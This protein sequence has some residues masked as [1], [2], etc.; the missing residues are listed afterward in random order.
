MQT[1]C[2]EEGIYLRTWKRPFNLCGKRDVK[3][4][5]SLFHASPAVVPFIPFPKV[6][7]LSYIHEFR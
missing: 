5:F 4:N 3:G 1:S 2:E 6:D 7:T